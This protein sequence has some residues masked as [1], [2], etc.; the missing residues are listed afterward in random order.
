M[1]K[2]AIIASFI[3]LVT[4]PRVF[5]GGGWPQPKG[6]FF[7]KLSQWWVISD[8]HYTNT[9]QID[10]NLT[11]GAYH[12]SIY[13]EYGITDRLTGIIY[14][15]FFSRATLNKQVSGTTGM[16]ISEGD[17]INSVGDTD[18]SVKYGLAVGQPLAIS[19][20]LTLGLPLGNDS[21]G[22]DGSL[23]TGDGE[24]NQII[25]VD[26]SK[27]FQIGR[28]YPYLSLNAGFNNRTN[29]YSDEFR[30]GAEA[31]ITYKRL[32]AIVRLYGVQ[33]LRNGLENF[34]AMGTSLFANNSEYLSFTPELAYN[35]SDAIGISASY[36][37][38]FSGQLIFA[39]PSYAVGVFVKL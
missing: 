4:T 14:F 21:G 32:T 13:G 2:I 18:I 25:A 7:L 28:Y 36:G 20:T 39:N 24:F 17:A 11:R 37:T 22:R 35:F 29:N 34:N 38:A 27:S 23:Q 31:G 19:A 26:V 6:K 30:Y 5:A 16:T 10:P 9:G 15:P 12:T 3:L 1:K 33:S 8:Q